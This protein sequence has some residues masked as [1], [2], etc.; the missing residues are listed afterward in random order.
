MDVLLRAL[1]ESLA[2]G[3][4]QVPDSLA[5]YHLRRASCDLGSDARCVRLV[6]QRAAAY[7]RRLA[8]AAA[9]LTASGPEAAGT[10]AGVAAAAASA[11]VAAASR[12]GGGR[13]RRRPQGAEERGAAEAA[14]AAPA[15]GAERGPK[16][17]RA[18]P[19]LAA[20]GVP[21]HVASAAAA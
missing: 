18:G 14:E 21:E 2:S 10:S 11:S 12:G 4:A 16:V 3:T 7:A 5:A 13:K 20:L 8:A 9:E 15:Q 1:G 19:L 6:A 17:L